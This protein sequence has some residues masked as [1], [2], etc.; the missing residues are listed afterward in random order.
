MQTR[1]VRTRRRS[2]GTRR[3][4]TLIELMIVIAIVGIV[5]GVAWPRFIETRRRI[6]VESSAQRLLRDLGLAR[7]E[8]IK[9]N[10]PVSLRRL[11]DNSYQIDSVAVRALDPGVLFQTGA[12]VIV[13]FA[14][15]GP[16]STGSAS[17]RLTRGAHSKR[18]EINTAGFARTTQ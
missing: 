12:P 9:R 15:Y 8:A 1:T 4:V 6:A 11:S 3:G 2:S 17:F 18:V 16:L 5:A 7:T 13:T 10:R 14:P